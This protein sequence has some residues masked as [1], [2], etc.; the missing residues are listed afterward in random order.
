MQLKEYIHNIESDLSSFTETFLKA[1][2]PFK[3]IYF[4]RIEILKSEILFFEANFFDFND[5]LFFNL[6]IKIRSWKLP[7]LKLILSR[8]I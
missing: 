6:S 4:D 5:D 2:E 1:L 7:F 8:F 3:S